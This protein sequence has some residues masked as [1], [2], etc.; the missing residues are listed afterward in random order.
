MSIENDILSEVKK[1]I[2]LADSSLSDKIYKGQVTDELVY[3]PEWIR[4]SLAPSDF[5][6][7]TLNA[8]DRIT[9]LQINYYKKSGRRNDYNFTSDIK[10]LIIQS[11]PKINRPYW[12]NWELV[13]NSND[14]DIE[15]ED[16]YEGFE[17]LFEFR[18]VETLSC[19]ALTYIT[20]DDGVQL[21]SEDG[22]LI[23]T[24]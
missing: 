17:L 18:T 5:I 9:N 12:Y 8:Q 13:D 14:I 15:V 6:P 4:L 19:S 24:D 20:D 2:L 21:I 3:L 22:Y 23:I 1:Q 11:L 16:E 7:L 10:D